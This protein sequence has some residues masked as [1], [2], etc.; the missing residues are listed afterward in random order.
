MLKHGLSGTALI[1]L[2]VLLGTLFLIYHTVNPV[3]Q[4]SLLTAGR[5]PVFF[6]RL[7]LGAIALLAVIVLVQAKPLDHDKLRPAVVLRT[8]A[9]IVCAGIYIQAITAVGFVISSIL[10]ALLMPIIMGYRR[11]T[12]LIPLAAFY[13]VIVWYIFEKVFLIILPSSPWFDFF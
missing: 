6:P 13:C 9:A 3:Y 5:G 12:I 4:T 10:F 11:L 8:V 2:V 7:L 1:G